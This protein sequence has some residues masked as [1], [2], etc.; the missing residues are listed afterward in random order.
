MYSL[1][2]ITSVNVMSFRYDTFVF[3]HVVVSGEITTTPL[4]LERPLS[5][6]DS[7]VSSEETV[8]GEYLAAGWTHEISHARSCN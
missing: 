8:G 4:T 1:A 3:P 6:V 5:C 2:S 7:H